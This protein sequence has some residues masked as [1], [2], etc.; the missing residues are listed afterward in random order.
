MAGM[1]CSCTGVGLLTP[2][3]LHCLTSQSERPS[4]AKSAMGT[5]VVVFC[6]SELEAAHAR[7]RCRG[8]AVPSRELNGIP[9]RSGTE[10]GRGHSTESRTSLSQKDS[11]AR[12]A[13]SF[14]PSVGPDSAKPATARNYAPGT[15]HSAACFCAESRGGQRKE[16]G[17]EEK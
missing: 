16:G 1:Q 17:Q 3:C 9:V 13:S 6:F 8:S 11:A 2:S 15:T 14:L 10:A 4:D 5:F 7:W 12:R